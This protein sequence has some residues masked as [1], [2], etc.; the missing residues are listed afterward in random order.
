MIYK[1]ATV[2]QVALEKSTL[3]GSLPVI[4]TPFHNG[5]VDYDSLLRLFDHLFPDLDGYT[6]GGSTGEAVSMTMTERLELIR[7]AASN[8]PAGK[9]IVIGLTHTDLQES[10]ELLRAASDAGV[11]AGLVPSPYYFPNSFEMVREYMRALAGAGNL[12]LVFYDNPVTTKT[13]FSATQLLEL[14]QVCPSIKAIKM[15]DHAL[16]KVT[17][18]KDGGIDVFAGDDVVAFR[19]LLLGVKGSMIIAPAIFPV[20]YQKTI[21]QLASGDQTGAL[22]T[23]SLKILP[24]IHLF[25][26]GDEIA[27]TKGLYEHLGI[28]RSGELRLPLLP[29]SKV[30][31]SHAILAYEFCTR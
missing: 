6:I 31:L 9:T 10:Q 20:A 26:I 8:T 13:A 15:T 17:A 25:G 30:R 22:E 16:E 4:P 5:K 2:T 18:L 12:P 21:S 1:E 11:H 29:S 24:F 23:F 7:F 3:A 19:S 27:V 28:F 14:V